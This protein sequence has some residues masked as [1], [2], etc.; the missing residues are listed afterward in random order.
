MPQLSP[1]LRPQG[2]L[3]HGRSPFFIPLARAVFMT[4]RKTCS[5]SPSEPPFFV[6]GVCPPPLGLRFM[7][8]CAPRRTHASLLCHPCAGAR[9][10]AR[11][12][13][14]RFVL[15]LYEGLAPLAI[16]MPPL[17]GLPS[18]R[19]FGRGELPHCSLFIV[20]C[21]LPCSLRRMPP[22][23]LHPQST[24]RLALHA[25]RAVCSCIFL[26]PLARR[27]F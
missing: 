15:F 19:G 10:L 2:V 6:P 24:H 21:A 3:H 9:P 18:S 11:L 1:P 14:F 8:P 26:R 20:Y 13:G 22:S 27:S 5:S 17:P 25:E 7:S 16:A 23:S 4:G 12:A